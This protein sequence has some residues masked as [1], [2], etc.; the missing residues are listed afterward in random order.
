MTRRPPILLV[1]VLLALNLAGGCRRSS[2]SAP[3]VGETVDH[4]RPK[5]NPAPETGQGLYSDEEAK[6]LI[7]QAGAVVP[8]GESRSKKKVL[9]AL[10]IDPRRLAGRRVVHDFLVSIET[11]QLSEGF[12]LTWMAAAQDPTPLDR[13]NREIYGVRVLPRSESN[14]DLESAGLLS[15]KPL[16]QTGSPP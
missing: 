1:W 12:D 3:G 9:A 8:V 16:Q 5:V 14:K 13:D 7:K 6:A 15:N 10:A 2:R 4:R 11:W